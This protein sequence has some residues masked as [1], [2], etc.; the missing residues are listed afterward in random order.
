[1]KASVT[2][3][4]STSDSAVSY[5]KK[6]SGMHTGKGFAS[7]FEQNSINSKDKVRSSFPTLTVRQLFSRS[8]GKNN[9][10]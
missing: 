4:D 1:M 5:F 7:S 10:P 2:K 3:F 6:L 9:L 8:F